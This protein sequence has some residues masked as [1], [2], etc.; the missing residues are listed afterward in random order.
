VTAANRNEAG[1]LIT[2]DATRANGWL[3][4]ARSPVR[5]PGLHGLR[6]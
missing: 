2:W 5:P 4:P 6:K 1:R 3:A